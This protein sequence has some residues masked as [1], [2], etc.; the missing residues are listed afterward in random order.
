MS[1][2]AGEIKDPDPVEPPPVVVWPVRCQVCGVVQRPERPT[3]CQVCGEPV[4]VPGWA[5]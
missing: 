1:K 5:P 2:A 3:V 4:L